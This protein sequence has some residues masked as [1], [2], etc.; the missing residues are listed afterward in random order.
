MAL[1]TLNL[2]QASE[3]FGVILLNGVLFSGSI[4]GNS[5]STNAWNG[6]LNGG[7]GNVNGDNANNDDNNGAR[8][9]LFKTMVYEPMWS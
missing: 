9:A 6:E 3:E 8:P 2:P 1:T 4:N 5:D 7:A